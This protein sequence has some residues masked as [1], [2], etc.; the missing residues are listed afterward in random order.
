[1]HIYLRGQQMQKSG[2]WG[3]RSVQLCTFL[4]RW[5]ALE[6]AQTAMA[7]GSSLTAPCFHD[8]LGETITIYTSK[9]SSP[10]YIAKAPFM[11]LNH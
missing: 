1:M 2:F 3:G 8:A 6:T 9:G 10:S 7:H 11:L 4:S 5:E